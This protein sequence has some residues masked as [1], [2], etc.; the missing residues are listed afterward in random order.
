M[1]NG[2]CLRESTERLNV[3]PQ[4][5]TDF[6]K[7]WAE[8][9]HRQNPRYWQ[10]VDGEDR[11][12][13]VPVFERLM[14]RNSVK[15]SLSLPLNPLFGGP[16]SRHD[17]QQQQGSAKSRTQHFADRQ[18]RRNDWRSA[19][20]TLFTTRALP[21]LRWFLPPANSSRNWASSAKSVAEYVECLAGVIKIDGCRKGLLDVG[22]ERVQIVDSGAD[23][24]A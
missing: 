14:P 19:V 15:H 22:I 1:I 16:T 8:N 17:D 24:N 18:P 2:P 20:R 9:G 5:M 4:I 23:F 3:S 10:L 21:R 6:E 13:P 11:R 12:L 7:V